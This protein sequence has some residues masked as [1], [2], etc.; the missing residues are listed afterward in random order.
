[1]SKPKEFYEERANNTWWNASSDMIEI[2]S[3]D[4]FNLM[5]EYA[6]SR[7]VYLVSVS[8][9]KSEDA[10]SPAAIS[11]EDFIKQ[12]TEYGQSFSL[13]GFQ[14]AVNEDDITMTNYYI[15]II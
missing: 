9:L 12:A 7:R 13:Q 4:L 1:M 5:Q 14:D 11:D 6:D 15:R 2:K 3:S 10:T 8:I